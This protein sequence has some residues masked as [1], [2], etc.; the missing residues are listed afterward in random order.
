MTLKIKR[1][2]GEVVDVKSFDDVIKAQEEHKRRNGDYLWLPNP[3]GGWKPCNKKD[4]MSFVGY[5]FF[6]QNFSNPSMTIQFTP[7]PDAFT[8]CE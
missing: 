8:L 4:P 6:L 1:K 3:Y 2:N 5:M 7:G